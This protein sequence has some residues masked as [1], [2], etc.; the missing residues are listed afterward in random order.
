MNELDARDYFARGEAPFSQQWYSAYLGGPIRRDKLHY[1]GSFE[2][3]RQDQTAVVTSP[4]LP[5]EYPQETRN[6][7][8]LTKLDYQIG[9]E[10]AHDVPLQLR[11]RHDRPTTAW[12]G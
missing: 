11:R 4:L 7:K 8:F 5:G 3:L 12:A 10:P 6:M 1:F 9:N 2:G